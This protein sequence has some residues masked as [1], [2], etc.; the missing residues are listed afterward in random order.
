MDSR[1]LQPWQIK[2]I[3]HEIARALSYLHRLARAANTTPNN[4]QSL[5]RQYVIR[6]HAP[7]RRVVIIKFRVSLLVPFA[8]PLGRMVR[9]H[10][11]VT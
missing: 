1:S 11:W 9:L 10:T 2:R 6:T 7:F 5:R 4:F 8:G 3:D